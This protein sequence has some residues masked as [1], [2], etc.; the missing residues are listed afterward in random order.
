MQDQHLYIFIHHYNYTYIRLLSCFKANIH[1]VI[2]LQEKFSFMFLPV[3]INDFCLW[4]FSTY[5]AL[6]MQGHPQICL[7]KSESHS[8]FL[9]CYIK[10]SQVCL[11]V[12]SLSW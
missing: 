3:V 7:Y 10:V 9:S 5:F 12:P 2:F 1:F 6:Q 4:L 8:Y 11:N